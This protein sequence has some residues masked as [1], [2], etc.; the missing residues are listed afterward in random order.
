MVKTMSG[1]SPSTCKIVPWSR[2]VARFCLWVL[3][4]RGLRV[5]YLPVVAP[6]MAPVRSTKSRRRVVQ[7]AG[8]HRFA[9]VSPW[10][11]CLWQEITRTWAV[12][13]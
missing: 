2:S 1:Y 8:E 3:A 6:T 5:R 7:N 10:T 13:G 12:P 4:N 9:C 11:R